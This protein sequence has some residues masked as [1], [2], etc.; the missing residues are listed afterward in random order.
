M[1]DPKVD[2]DATLDRLATN[3]LTI[4]ARPIPH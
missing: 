4:H 3:A 2:F 1:A